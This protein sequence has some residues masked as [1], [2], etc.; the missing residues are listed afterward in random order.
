MTITLER[1]DA[2][3]ARTDSHPDLPLPSPRGPRRDTSPFGTPARA[4]CE[5]PLPPGVRLVRKRAAAPS[6]TLG[7]KLTMLAPVALLA[8]VSAGAVTLTPHV[9]SLVDGVR[10]QFGGSASAATAHTMSEHAAPKHRATPSAA[11]DAGRIPQQHPH[12]AKHRAATPDPTVNT[13][14]GPH[15]TASAATPTGSHVAPTSGSHRASS[16]TDRT[17]STSTAKATG[18]KHKA[19]STPPPA[20]TPP[21]SDP[22]TPSSDPGSNPVTDL[23]DAANN[24]VKN[25]TGLDLHL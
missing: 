2:R 24:A 15:T 21:P 18:G 19:T 17:N 3:V 23:T 13:H 6:S 5:E 8:G 16:A 14:T 1:P 12:Q 25:L 11:P 20:D 10:D 9:Q 7:R 22:G 4:A